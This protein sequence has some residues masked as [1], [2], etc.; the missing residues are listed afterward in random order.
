MPTR[1]SRLQ[2]YLRIDTTNPPGR[3]TAEGAHYLAS[4]LHARNVTTQLL[5]T[6]EGRTS[7]YAKVEAQQQP[8]PSIVLL[9]HID[10]VPAGDGW[11]RDAF[12]GAIEEG[13][14][15]GR[16]AIDSKSLGIAHLEALFSLL[17][18]GGPR[19][20]ATSSTSPSPTKRPA[21]PRARPSSSSTIPISSRTQTSS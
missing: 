13:K 9:H 5:V 15:W 20:I 2:A 10:V 6:P 17:D 16:G 12:S 4:Q 11:S 18:E 21:V 1:T 8:A 7:L 3:E 19:S 14:I